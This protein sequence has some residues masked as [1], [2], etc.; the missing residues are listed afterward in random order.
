VRLEELGKLKKNATTSPDLEPA[1]F[2][3]FFNIFGIPIKR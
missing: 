1:T 2:P 3:F